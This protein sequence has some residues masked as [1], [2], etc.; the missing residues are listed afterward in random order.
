M[1][2][3]KANIVYSE[4][5]DKFKVYKNSYI[6]IE[7]G[8]VSGIWTILPDKYKGIRVTDYGEAV[9]I[10]AFSDLHVH[11][12]QYLNR[13]LEMDLL[14]PEWLEN[15]TFPMEA[16]FSDK[17][18]AKIVYDAFVDDMLANGTMHACVY[19]T[20]HLDST[21][22]LI[23]K[24]D[25]IGIKGYVGKVNMDT[26]SPSSLKENTNK[27]IIDT[28]TFLEKYFKNENTKPIITPRFAPTC[29]EKL[30][31]EL[32][33]LGKKYNVGTQTHIVESKWEAEQAKMLFPNCS[34]DTEIY[35][36]SGLFGNGPFIGGHFIFPSEEDKRIMKKY[37]GYV[38][39]CPDATINITA[40]IMSTGKLMDSGI[41]VCLG[42]D[43]SAGHNLGVYSQVAKSI[44]LSKIKEFYENENNRKITFA[45]SFYMAT[46]GSE[47]LFENTGSFE[48]GYSFDALVIENLSDNMRKLNP[49]QIVER[50]CYIGTKNNIK[51]RYLN[52]E[53]KRI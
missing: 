20:I 44:Q 32:G 34:C 25:K 11:A 21:S 43:I 27:S 37:N 1:L 26:N 12:P 52:G 2:I 6:V 45:E 33:K 39:Q 9:L 19:G 8:K 53:E 5:K 48:P 35:E 51:A 3:I 31:S 28:E 30:L 41:N 49:E 47:K 40:G 17:Q 15:C 46:K 18:F 23:E 7:N 38:V 13:G 22:Y 24:M 14:L 36:K 4:N 42:T 29:S 50:F 16:E 10:P